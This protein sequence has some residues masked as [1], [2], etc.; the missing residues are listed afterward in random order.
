MQDHKV[1]VIIAAQNKAEA[2]FKQ[3]GDQVKGFQKST[4]N[5]RGALKTTAI[6]GTAAFAAIGVAIAVSLKQAGEAEQGQARLNAV[7]KSTGG[8]AGVTAKMVNELA[9]SMS[10]LSTFTDDEII[11]AQS[12]ILQFTNIS[13]DIFPQAT[14]A[15]LDLGAKMGDLSGAA[16]TVARA[17][18]QPAEASRALRAANILLS[19]TEETLLKRLVETGKGAEAQRMILDKLASVTGGQAL[20]SAKSFSGVMM[21]VRNNVS[22]VFE[23]IG[24]SLLP[25]LKGAA[26]S[27]NNVVVK[28]VKWIEEHPNLVRGIIV[29]A[30]VITGLVAVLGTLGVALLAAQGVAITFGVTLAALT[31]PI[32]LVVG[33]IAVLGIGAGVYATK[34]GGAKDATEGLE[35]SVDALMPK[36]PDFSTGMGDAGR[37]AAE[38]AKQM[39][40]LRKEL[41]DLYKTAAQQEADANTQVAELFIEQEGKITDIKKEMSEK[42]KEINQAE[43]SDESTES[44]NRLQDEYSILQ[45]RLTTEQASLREHKGM[46]TGIETEYREAKRRSELSDFERRLED[47][48]K[49]RV[50]NLTA[51]NQRIID[52]QAEIDA[53]ETEERRLT[54]TVQVEADKQIQAWNAVASARLNAAGTSISKSTKTSTSAT[55]GIPT[56][57]S[58]LKFDM[59]AFGMASGGPVSAGSPYIVGE[60]G[61]E[62]FVPNKSGNVI[63]NGAGGTVVNIYNPMLLDDAMVARLGKQVVRVMNRDLRY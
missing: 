49:E 59:A 57:S 10:Q 6:A 13:K 46:L 58:G 38:T 15:A 61:P 5:L 22:E 40:Q 32:G 51:I 37:S 43:K 24:K 50:A 54:A 23:A 9:A 56:V 25:S 28:V 35:Q 14:Q 53:L 8:A 63:P 30:T 2:A 45:E 7:I 19:D 4:E 12:V 3:A 34:F 11:S 18:Q 36:L 48:L 20:A 27:F 41:Q 39:K 21:I 44:R 33:A 47:I 42:R 29:A 52:K 55:K 26:E 62:W 17:L 1:N 16:Q 31:G 60:K